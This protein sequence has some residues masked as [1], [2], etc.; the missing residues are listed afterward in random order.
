MTSNMDLKDT[1]DMDEV[2]SLQPEKLDMSK[3]ESAAK[4]EYNSGRY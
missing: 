3:I 1:E 4:W 2:L